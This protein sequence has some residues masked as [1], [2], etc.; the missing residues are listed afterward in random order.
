[1]HQL[2]C[3]TQTYITSSFDLCTGPQLGHTL[4]CMQNIHTHKIQVILKKKIQ[5][6]RLRLNPSGQGSIQDT[7]NPHRQ[8]DLKIML[9]KLQTELDSDK[10]D[11]PDGGL[12]ITM[13]LKI[14]MKKGKL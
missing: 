7:Q 2:T 1:M 5:N 8:N 13:M 11:S 6:T 14:L 12:K 9:R 4:T 10:T 3:S